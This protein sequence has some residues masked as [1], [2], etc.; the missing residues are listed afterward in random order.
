MSDHLS[1]SQ[2][3]LLLV[4]LIAGGALVGWW[5]NGGRESR[6]EEGPIIEG[7]ADPIV[8]PANLGRP[9]I[10]D[11]ESPIAR[12]LNSPE[13]SIEEDLKIVH[14]CLREFRE[15]V[16]QGNPVGTNEEITRSLSGRNP[17]LFA[18]LPA[19]HS[20]ISPDGELLDRWGTPYFFHQLS[21]DVMKVRSAGPDRIMRTEDD[22]VQ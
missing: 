11:R 9:S 22:I 12:E 15:I 3:S 6:P 13:G 1:K 21:A 7:A 4:I 20:A 8:A 2:L 16:R 19:D 10:P 18:P 17:R 14:L 5:L